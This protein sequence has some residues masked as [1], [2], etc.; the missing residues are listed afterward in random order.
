MLSQPLI[1]TVNISIFIAYES[2]PAIK[3]YIFINA[4]NLWNK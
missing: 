4:N 1:G 2:A 3:E